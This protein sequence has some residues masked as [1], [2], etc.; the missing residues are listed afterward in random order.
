MLNV[1]IRN[2]KIMEALAFFCND[3]KQST[4]SESTFRWSKLKEIQKRRKPF[5]MLKE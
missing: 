4:S 1:I 3:L 5:F 2:E